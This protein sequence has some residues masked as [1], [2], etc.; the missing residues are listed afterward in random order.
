MLS[1]H[2]NCKTK[3]TKNT[4]YIYLKMNFELLVKK[5]NNNI[6]IVE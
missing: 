1:L 4:N 3:I 6:K 5:L 2:C